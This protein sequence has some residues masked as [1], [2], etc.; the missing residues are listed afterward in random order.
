MRKIKA[1]LVENHELT[2]VE[3]ED[4]LQAFYDTID[5]EL[6][7]MIT[8]YINGES[9]CFIIDEEGRLKD[10]KKNDLEALGIDGNKRALEGIVGSFLIVGVYT[11]NEAEICS[12]SAQEIAEIKKYGWTKENILVYNFR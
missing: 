10:H 2:E 7:E 6:V 8:R 5:C 4:N 3:I 11:I 12:L 1:L 9:Y